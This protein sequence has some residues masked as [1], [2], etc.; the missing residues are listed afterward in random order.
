M[1]ARRN[2][3]LPAEPA[4]YGGRAEPVAMA[5]GGLHDVSQGKKGDVRI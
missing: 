2:Q 4:R 3:Q 5:P 1:T